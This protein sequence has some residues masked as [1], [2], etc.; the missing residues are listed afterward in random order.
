MHKPLLSMLAAVCAVAFT[1]VAVAAESVPTES[2][3]NPLQTFAPFDYP[4]AVNRYRSANGSPGPDYWKNRADY[5][6][7]AALDPERKVLQG[8]ETITYTN[9]SPDA[10]HLL[11]LQ[12]DQNRYRIDARAN[13]ASRGEPD[14]VDHTGGFRIKSVAVETDGGFQPARFVE[15]DTRMR[16]D[17]PQP[18]AAN[19]GRVRLHIV[20]SYT[21]PGNFGGRTDWYQTK[22]G[23]VFEV[24]QWYPRMAVYDDLRGWNTLPFTNNEFYLDYGDFDYSV[25]VP[26]NMIVVGSGKLVNPDDVLTDAQRERLEQARHSDTT[27][28]I[29]TPAEVTD[30]ASRPVQHG[31][32]TWHFRMRNTRDVAFGASAAYVWDA[33]RINLPSE[34]T[35]L[36]MSAYPV[37]SIKTGEW[38]RST[39]FVKA[40]IEFFSNY[41]GVEYPWPVAVAEAGIAGGM[42]YPGIV[43]DWWKDTSMGLFGLTVHEFGHDWFPMIV[44]SNERRD[45]WMDEGINTFVDVLAARWYNN[46]EFA[47][48]RDGEYAPGG[49]NPVEEIQ[50]VLKDPEAPP[51]MTL[52]DVIKGKYRHPVTYFKAALGLVLLRDQILGAERFDKAFRK[53]VHDWAFKHPSPSDFFR[54]MESAAGEDLSWFWRGWFKHNWNLDMAVEGVKYV[55]DDPAKGALITIA[56][57]DKLVMPTTLEVTFVD[58]GTRRIEVPVETWQRHHTFE[59]LTPGGKQVKSATIDPDHA[60]PDGNRANNTFVVKGSG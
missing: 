12:L 20:Y 39:E 51:I 22:N 35:A 4:Q 1:N 54:S 21:I 6:I 5:R 9:N 13:F 31:T 3:F 45:A 46:G 40:T 30:P 44:G 16:V 60:I 14:P 59:V 25:T 53:Y 43:F 49:G 15:S 52:P 48:K 37:E 58:G 27:V 32:L 34:R 33:A 47:P 2:T 28:M 56:N 50:S 24:A 11:W 42:E 18:L 38:E 17:L 36:A 10:L 23:N 8:S 57:L 19:G 55:D 7:S 41:T 29:R 26:W